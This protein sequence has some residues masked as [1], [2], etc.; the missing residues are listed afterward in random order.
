MK[1]FQSLIISLFLSSFIFSQVSMSIDN[2]TENSLSV[3]MDNSVDVG[4]FQFLLQY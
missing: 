2:V 1:Y 3:I 4:G